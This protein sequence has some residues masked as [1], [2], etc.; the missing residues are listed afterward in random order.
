ME[1]PKAAL[2]MHRKNEEPLK[3][4]GGGWSTATWR[5]RT[6]TQEILSSL[7]RSVE[8]WSTQSPLLG[9]TITKFRHY[10]AQRQLTL[11]MR[12]RRRVGVGGSRCDAFPQALNILTAPPCGK[13]PFENG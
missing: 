5:E 3:A 6:K 9:F 4:R 1:T 11:L 7:L 2:T 12:I 8:P 10:L 13:C